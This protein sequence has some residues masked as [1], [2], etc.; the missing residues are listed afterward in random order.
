[1]IAKMVSKSVDTDHV[2][3][4]CANGLVQLELHAPT[5]LLYQ[6]VHIHCSAV[7]GK[8]VDAPNKKFNYS[9]RGAYNVNESQ[10]SGKHSKE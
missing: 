8:P 1:M 6:F 2:I 7:S 9:S 3:A 5:V 4:Y 10:C